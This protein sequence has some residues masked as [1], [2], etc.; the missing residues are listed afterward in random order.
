MPLDTAI[1]PPSGLH[2]VGSVYGSPQTACTSGWA[3][4]ASSVPKLSSATANYV[5]GAC[6]LSTGQTFPVFTSTSP[7]GAGASVTTGVAVQRP[8]GSIYSFTCS[9][10]SCTTNSDIPLRLTASAAGYTF[11]DEDDNTEIYDT[12]GVLQSITYRG[13][14]QQTL[15]YVGGKLASVTDS[16]GRSLGFTYGSG[17][18]LQTLTTP[19]G[20]IQYTYDS[21]ARLMTV[22]YPDQT[23][24]KYV[25]GNVGAASL[26]GLIDEQGGN[27]ESWSYDSQGRA[28]ANSFAGGAGSTSVDYADPDNPKVTDALGV[29]RT[30][31][32]QMINN[33]QKLAA[34]SGSP[35]K[36]CGFPAS[37]GYDGAGFYQRTSD[38]NGNVTGYTY[39]ELRGL[40]TSRT[41]ASG[42]PLV[43][44][45]TT[46]WNPTFRLPSA[47]AEPHRTTS[48]TYDARGN[49]LTKTITDT[50]VMP[51]ASRTWTYTYDSYGRML[52][53]DG[54]RTDVSDV[55]TFTYYSCATG[56][57]CGQAHTITNA[58]G[59]ITTFNTY[60][61]DGQPLTITDPNGIVTTLTYDARQRLTSRQIGSETT[62]FTY[63]PTGLLKQVVLAD[64]SYLLYAYDAAHRLTQISD[65]LG[66]SIDYTLDGMG[67]RTAENLYDPSNT[68]HRIHTR[69]FNTLSQLFQNVN[70]A[71]TAAV[72]TTFGYDANGNQ[73]S[74]AAPL[75]RNTINAYDELNRLKQIT[76]PANGITQFVYD[77]NDNLTGVTDPR[78]LATVYAYSGFGDLVTQASPDTG[79][80][81]NTYDS[82]GNLATSTDARGAV[83]TYTYDALNR[84][85]SVAYSQGGTTDQTISFTYDAG[86]NGQGHLTGASDANQSMTWT[87]DTLGRVTGKSQ[88]VGRVTR[89]VAYTYTNGNL[90]SQTTPSGQTVSFG[91]NA[92]HQMTSVTVNGTTL[93]NSVVYEP[94]GP[95]SGWT[96][97]NGSTTNRTYDT[98]GKISQIVSAGTKTYGYDDAFRITGISDTSTGASN[99]TYG[100]D[101]LDRITSGTS[102]SI[103]RGW[104][105]DANGNRLTETGTA[106]SAYSISPTNNR[107]TGIT[108]ALARAYGYDAAGNTTSYAT[109]AATYNNAGRLTTLTQGGSTETALH[110]ALGQRIQKSG[111]SAGT[112]LFGY[113]EAGHLQG[114]YD[115]TG[116][117]I[118]E[119]VWLGDIP[120]ATLRPNGAS[121]SVYYVHSDQLN[122]PRQITRPSDNAQMWTWFSDPFGTDAANA[123]PS[124][125]GAF[126]Y[127]LRFA[128]QIFDGQAG[129][130][131]NG[132]RD[133]YDPATGRYCQSDPLGLRAGINTY[134]YSLG[135]PLAYSD[136]TGLDIWVEGPSASEPSFHQ[137]VNVGDPNGQY[138]SYS[139][140]MNGNGVQGEVY[141]DTS[142][143]G[144]IEAYKRTTPQE[145]AAYKKYL[146]S[147]VGKTGIYGYDDICRSWTQRQFTRAPGKPVPPPPRPVAPHLNISPSTSQTTTGTSSTTGTGTSR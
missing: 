77:A 95:V 106:P 48:F 137:S 79:T 16:F 36:S 97:G 111:G 49:A 59:Q 92:N 58:A 39:D 60:N 136:P 139:F 141:R 53:S 20:Q 4:I 118:E 40:E 101:A 138:S 121:I 147:Q 5:N 52:T 127:N 98:D 27:Y 76:D 38:W 32:L 43:R 128:G 82:A 130:H 78:G 129:L 22:T 69:V 51:N 68:L 7:I 11:T 73:T 88:T 100:Y 110:N 61:A 71:G 15:T 29:Q 67:N 47:V 134:A 34:I 90:T 122:T 10:G 116:A 120:V 114:E 102:P 37:I 143:G 33:R 41:E 81:V 28:Y 75:A 55:K 70:A 57:Q 86:P 103:S 104:T 44:T 2:F 23:V 96:W 24:R 13:G 14:Y 117:L 9:A 99:W 8:D 140:G 89:A 131:Q 17:S 19:S 113:D 54:P 25:Y 72:T 62:S 45:I 123:N 144:P 94:L 133:C 142:L 50:S 87:Y 21:S 115:G 31:Q 3:Q 65:G 126:A 6:K 30:Y 56:F 1:T 93:L 63:W 84:V 135:Q 74:I 146:E 109:V 112:V 145:D 119:T 132:Y 80:T 124:G 91:Y 105:Y 66:N 125:L 18:T 26:T 83:S 64:G 42:T 46:T 107:I 12:S 108:G 35:C 85:I